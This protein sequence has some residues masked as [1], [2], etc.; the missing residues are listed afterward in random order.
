MGTSVTLDP[1]AHSQN[2]SPPTTS[3]FSDRLLEK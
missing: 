3:D 1:M 2:P